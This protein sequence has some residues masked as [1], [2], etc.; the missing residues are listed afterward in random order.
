L[1]HPSVVV[2]R[3]PGFAIR[4]TDTIVGL[5][6]HG[7]TDRETKE[8]SMP[9]FMDVHEKVDGL[10]ADAVHREAHGLGRRLDRRGQGRLIK[11]TTPIAR[12]SV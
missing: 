8:T 10:T 7:D 6:V 2:S 11:P 3:R 12:Q 1:I 4:G 5:L 9:L